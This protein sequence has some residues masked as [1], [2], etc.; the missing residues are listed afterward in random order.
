MAMIEN[1][2]QEIECP[3]C[4]KRTLVNGY[5]YTGCFFPY[6]EDSTVC[7]CEAKDGEE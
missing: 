4:G 2:Y 3:H 1:V 7:D 5:Y 6:D